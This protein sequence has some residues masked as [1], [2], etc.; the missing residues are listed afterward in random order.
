MVN[1]KN[2]LSIRIKELRNASRLTQEELAEKLGLNNKSSIANYESGYSTPSDVIKLKMCE[3]FNCSMD[4][5]MG[6]TLFKNLNE[7]LSLVKYTNAKFDF[8][9]SAEIIFPKIDMVIK[10]I[11]RQGVHVYDNPD[12][13]YNKILAISDIPD[14]N[15]EIKTILFCMVEDD[16]TPEQVNTSF[17]Y[18]HNFLNAIDG[19]TKILETPTFESRNSGDFS[20]IL[21]A[22]SDNKLYMCPVYGRIAAGVPNWAE[23]CMEGTLPLD[24]YMMNIHNPEECF[25]LRVSGESM[26]R[27]IKNGGYALI[28]KQDEVDNGDIAVVLVNGYDA[29]LK[30]FTKKNDTIV[31]EPMSD[32]ESIE[33]QIYDSTTQIKILGKYIGKFELN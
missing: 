4:Y 2:I 28:R 27:V 12:E 22:P 9:D 18:N 5:L 8:C 7:K 33:I 26:N 32:D 11:L 23:Q 14:Y 19:D 21:P 30:K 16:I 15:C 13:L 24:P 10:N 3:I 1:N 17:W 25:F 29:T 20:N 31:L 6:K